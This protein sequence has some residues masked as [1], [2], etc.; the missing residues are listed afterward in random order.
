MAAL[1]SIT[2]RSGP[3]PAEVHPVGRFTPAKTAPSGS[4]SLTSTLVAAAE[5][6][7]VTVNVYVRLPVGVNCG[8]V[9]VLVIAR[10]AAN[11]GAIGVV[12]VAVLSAMF[13]SLVA[14]LT[15]AVLTIGGP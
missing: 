5:P 7:F 9:T 2:V 14:E 15:E 4:T 11:G 1:L 12:T 8:G 3:G 6:R 10:F 13:G